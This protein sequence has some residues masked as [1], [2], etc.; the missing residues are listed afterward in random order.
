MAISHSETVAVGANSDVHTTAAS[1]NDVVNLTLHNP[2][3]YPADVSVYLVPSG[4]TKGAQ[5]LID[6]MILGQFDT[7]ERTGV[8]MEAGD[9]INVTNG[10]FGGSVSVNVFGMRRDV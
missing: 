3:V 5:H 10:T 1:K 2:N 4:D 8:Q 7:Y 9:K 6:R